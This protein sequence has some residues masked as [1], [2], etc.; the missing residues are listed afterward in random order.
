MARITPDT[1]PD[2][3]T[4]E[5]ERLFRE[6]KCCFQTGFGLPWN[7]YCNTASDPDADFG[8]CYEHDDYV[9]DLLN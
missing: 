6:G 2:R 3:F 1:D 9:Q 5:E 7:E 8:Y 4:E